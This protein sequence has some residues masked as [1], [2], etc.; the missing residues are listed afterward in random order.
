MKNNK[1]IYNLATL[2]LKIVL[3]SSLLFFSLSL[4]AKKNHNPND[5]LLKASL[6]VD[7]ENTDTFYINENGFQYN[8][9]IS[10]SDWL[11]R[12]INNQKWNDL[13][14]RPE[15]KYQPETAPKETSY[16]PDFLTKLLTKI[17]TA[18]NSP[19]G[20]LIMWILLGIII[21]YGLYLILK[22]N[23]FSVFQNKNKNFNETLNASEEQYLPEQW[24]HLILESEKEGNYRLAT[25]H[26]FRH[27][28]TLLKSTGQIKQND[29][30][31]NYDYLRSF[32]NKQQKDDFRKLL[33]HYEY[34]WYGEF[35]ID[36][37]QYK[38]VALLYQSLKSKIKP[39]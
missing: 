38:N 28:I 13:R 26:S 30:A 8:K 14:N 7:P 3:A 25:R 1:R 39:L 17:I 18:L 9:N 2:R 10:T 6:N 24:A 23:G 37:G 29:S 36:A 4:L 35:T 15:Y 21:V 31:S 33:K 34:V 20:I 11:Q 16:Q 19:T 22:K 12:N 27:I 32:S 5:S